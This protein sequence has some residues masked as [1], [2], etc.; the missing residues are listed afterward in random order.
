MES[1]A[2]LRIRLFRKI[3][4]DLGYRNEKAESTF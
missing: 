4:K 1:S 2:E 3:K